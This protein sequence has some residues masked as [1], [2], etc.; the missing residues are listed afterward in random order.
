VSALHEPARPFAA[1]WALTR[2]RLAPLGLTDGPL[3][4][5][6]AARS[7][8][9][10]LTAARWMVGP[11]DRPT[12][13]C[14]IVR[15]L[16]AAAEIV[17]AMIFPAIPARLPV[18]AAELLAFGGRPRLTFLDLQAPGLEPGVRADVAAATRAA[19]ADFAG[20][21]RDPKPPGWAVAH[22]PGGYLF[23]RTDDPAHAPALGAA[24][25]TYLDVWI[26]LAGRVAD[27]GGAG[28][29][30]ALAAYKREHVAHS[31]GKAFLGKVFGDDWTDRFLNQ[32]LYG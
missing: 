14:R 5:E 2:A 6:F 13:E 23:T 21:P 31:P 16:G 22:S 29:A 3:D 8:R 15:I 11:T 7:G 27:A 9:M 4:P 28:G 25:R 26:D 24:Y 30:D 10:R 12:A 1:L 17:N 32:F 18:F 20:M 19:S